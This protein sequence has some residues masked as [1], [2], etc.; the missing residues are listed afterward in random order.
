MQVLCP[1]VHTNQNRKT[2]AVPIAGLP[3]R[4]TAHHISNC[5]NLYLFGAMRDFFENVQR[6]PR[7]LISFSLG[8]LYTFVE[9]ILPLLKRP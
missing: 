5:D 9:P 3:I 8:V 7:Y 1:H 6:Y 2:R 4:C